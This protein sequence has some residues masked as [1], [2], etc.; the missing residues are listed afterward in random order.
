[1]TLK[2]EN[3]AQIGDTIKAYDHEPMEGRRDRYVEGVVI[4]KGMIPYRDFG[5]GYAAYTIRVT[6]DATF[7]KP[8]HNRIGLEVFVPFES[9]M[10]YDGRVTV[11]EQEEEEEDE[12]CWRCNGPADEGVCMDDCLEENS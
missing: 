11:I 7:T 8:D 4:E 12:R 10:D 1:M 9:D 5:G 6:A 3:T 2:Y